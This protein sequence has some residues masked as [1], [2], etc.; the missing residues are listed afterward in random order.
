MLIAFL[1]LFYAYRRL[2]RPGVSKEVRAMFF[3]KHSLYVGMFIFIWTIQLS[4]NYYALMNPI[5]VPETGETYDQ[6]PLEHLAES[7]GLRGDIQQAN[8]NVSTE[9]SF[10]YQLSGFMTFSAGIFLSSVRFV[11]PLFR[12][13]LWTYL[14]QFFG[15]IYLDSGNVP[16]EYKIV[17]DNVLSSFLAS[18][19]NVELVFIILKSVTTLTKL[20]NSN[21]QIKVFSMNKQASSRYQK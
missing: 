4:Q 20:S 13:M 19:L 9:E 3:K 16:E 8:R 5:V 21:N 11:E 12:V 18:S 1:S 15:Q 10:A 7:L 14:Y 6:D 2:E 17:K